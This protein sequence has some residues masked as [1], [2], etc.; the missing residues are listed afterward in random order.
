MSIFAYVYLIKITTS[1]FHFLC[2]SNRIRYAS[3]LHSS[4]K[5][6]TV[7]PL[8]TIEYVMTKCAWIQF[9]KNLVS[10]SHSHSPPRELRDKLIYCPRGAH[11]GKKLDPWQIFPWVGGKD[12]GISWSRAGSLPPQ[13]KASFFFLPSLLLRGKLSK[14]C[15]RCLFYPLMVLPISN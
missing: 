12:H 14:I 1:N 9:C 10:F 5:N 13:W 6:C 7:D 11:Q 4:D 15:H 2:R 8:W 3:P